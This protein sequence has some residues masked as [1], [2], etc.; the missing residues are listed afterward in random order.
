V[1]FVGLIVKTRAV[2][3][4]RLTSVLYAATLTPTPKSHKM[5]FAASRPRIL[6]LEQEQFVNRAALC[7]SAVAHLAAVI[8]VAS[9]RINRA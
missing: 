7:M 8:K 3:N 5:D 6:A 1:D 9:D 2:N 4:G